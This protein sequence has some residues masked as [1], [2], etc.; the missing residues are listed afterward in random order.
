MN[1]GRF[2]AK[3]QPFMIHYTSISSQSYNFNTALV[4][5]DGC[6]IG[7]A[8]V[9]SLI[10]DGKKVI[11]IGRNESNLDSTTKEIGATAYYILDTGNTPSISESVKT[12]ISSTPI[13]TVL[14][15]KLVSRDP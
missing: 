1:S 10:K 13:S 6:G 4:T 11:I 14:S 3:L 12:I 15:I 8:L 2:Y 9:P 7:K 5:G